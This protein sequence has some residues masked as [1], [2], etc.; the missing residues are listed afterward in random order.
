MKFSFPI[1]E[2]LILAGPVTLL[3]A[4]LFA[5]AGGAK[6]IGSAGMVQE[7]AQ[8]GIGQW[9]RYFTGILV[10]SVALGVLF[11]RLRFR[12]ALQIAAVMAGATVARAFILHIS[13]WQ[14]THRC[15][16]GIGTF[17]RVAMATR[18]ESGP[19]LN[20]SRVIGSTFAWILAVLLAVV[21]LYAGGA[22]LA[23][24]PGMVRE[25]A[26]IGLSQ[27]LRY[28]TGMLE[29]SGAV[30]VLVPTLRFWAALLIAAVMA[31]ATVTNLFILHI[32]VL[33]RLTA[34]LLGLA[35]ALAWLRRPQSI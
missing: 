8:I 33:A 27:W 23:S 11:P 4:I 21:F 13:V 12:A 17:S 35:F 6:L 20:K 16:H 22:K 9:F 34:G 3:V 32:P 30:G 2:W 19:R 7:F 25:F 24:N 1:Y 18:H 31:G 14:T 28:C 5:A 10:V 15:A 26:Q 29:V